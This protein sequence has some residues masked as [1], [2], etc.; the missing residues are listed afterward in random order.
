MQDDEDIQDI[1]DSG[2]RLSGRLKRYAKVGSSVGGLAA[3]V[4]GNR[5]L[6]TG[7][8]SAKHSIELK[9]ALGGL[10]GPLMKAAQILA[11][12]PDALP[13][14]YAEELRQLQSNAPSMGW[15]FVKRR[16]K[17]ELGAGWQKKFQSF[18][19][20]ATAAASLGQVHRAIDLDG[21]ELACK[22]Q[23]PDMISAV[24]ADLKQLALLFG[25]YRRYDKAI[26]PSNILQE[27]T[28]RLREELDYQRE[29]QNMGLYGVMLANEKHVCVPSAVPELTTNRLITMN[30]LDG[31]PLLDFIKSHENNLEMCNQ[32][33]MNMFRA[34]YVPFYKYGVIHGDPHLGNYS[35]RENGDVNLLDFGCVRVFDASFVK[36]V[37][38]LY[39][40]L[41][42]DDEDL[43]VQAYESWGFKIQSREMLDT[44][45]IW[46]HFLYGPLLQD[47]KRTI[48]DDYKGGAYGAEVANKVHQELRRLGGVKPPR[49]FVLMDRAAVGL[50]SVFMHL[51]AEINWHQLF[52]DLISDFDYEELQ[53]RQILALKQFNV[54]IPTH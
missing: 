48:V 32:V 5:V 52:H 23:Y 25:I 30:W 4:V 51:K 7:L 41:E 34:W 40:G 8:N 17:T 36:G 14:E 27:L 24:E 38:D 50:G 12:I 29:A 35:I 31:V 11:T 49:E 16:M 9:K 43:A 53:K 22:L 13:K 19:Q 10:K 1:S 15:L 37:I 39:F 54:P 6:G 2:S 45:N 18:D 33:A 42:R 21:Q 44:L 3:Q 20:E 46:A 26:D 47:R 28:D